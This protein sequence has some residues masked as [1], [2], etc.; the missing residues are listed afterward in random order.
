MEK[1]KSSKDDRRDKNIGEVPRH[2]GMMMAKRAEAIFGAQN[3]C[4]DNDKKRDGDHPPFD[5]P[6]C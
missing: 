1:I 6:K 2:V 3:I 4:Q 5:L